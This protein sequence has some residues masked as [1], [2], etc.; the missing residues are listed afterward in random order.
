MKKRKGLK[1]FFF[2]FFGLFFIHKIRFWLKI[3]LLVIWLLGEP[4]NRRELQLERHALF[5]NHWDS[6]ICNLNNFILLVMHY[7][8]VCFS[9]YLFM[10]FHLSNFS[11][12]SSSFSFNYFY[13]YFYLFIYLWVFPFKN[14]FLKYNF[15][16][17]KVW[18]VVILVDTKI[19]VIG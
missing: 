14:I 18:R 6:N 3:K 10:P 19:S 2:F 8:Q 12:S 9:N 5:S 16:A 7:N 13:F 1:G 11:S 15:E 4:T 17:Y